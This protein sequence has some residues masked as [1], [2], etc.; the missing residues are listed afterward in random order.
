MRSSI[1][2]GNNRSKAREN[3]AGLITSFEVVLFGSSRVCV[4]VSAQERKE[5]FTRFSY[6]NGSLLTWAKAAARSSMQSNSCAV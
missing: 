6:H 2:I 3:P 1:L 5:K 4:Q